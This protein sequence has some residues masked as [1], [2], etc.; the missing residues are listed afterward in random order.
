MVCRALA[1]PMLTET[2]SGPRDDEIVVF[3]TDSRS[4]SAT[5]IACFIVV[6]GSK[7]TNSSPPYR[8]QRSSERK[9]A[10]AAFDAL[11]WGG[12]ARLMAVLVVEVLEVVDID[13]QDRQ[14]VVVAHAARPFHD[15][16]LNESTAIVGVRQCVAPGLITVISS[17][18][19]VAMYAKS[20]AR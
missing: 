9:A 4:R 2:P 15:A 16:E 5:T 19:P 14:R 20:A 18:N 6:L 17:C 12:V 1:T 3:A 7:A 11:H 8:H 10:W 13:R